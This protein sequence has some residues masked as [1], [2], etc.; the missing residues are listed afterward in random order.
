M[1][2]S[3]NYSRYKNDCFLSS[4]Y[5]M[6]EKECYKGLSLLG[7]MSKEDIYTMEFRGYKFDAVPFLLNSTSYL[8]NEY[9]CAL[10]SSVAKETMITEPFESVDV[11]KSLG[12]DYS[13]YESLIPS[14]V[15]LGIR[16]LGLYYYTKQPISMAKLLFTFFNESMVAV[17][18][19]GKRPHIDFKYKDICNTQAF[20]FYLSLEWLLKI[21]PMLRVMLGVQY[22]KVGVLDLL[23]SFCPEDSIHFKYIKGDITAGELKKLYLDKSLPDG[24]S[25]CFRELTSLS[26]DGNYDGRDLTEPELGLCEDVYNL[27]VD[28]MVYKLNENLS[29]CMLYDGTY[30]RLNKNIEVLSNSVEELKVKVSAEKKLRSEYSDK[31]NNLKKEISEKETEISTLKHKLSSVVSYDELTEKVS[32]LSSEL[33]SEVSE[34]KSLF[35]ERLEL[36]RL[37]SSQSKEIK[38]LKA[39]LDCKENIS[40]G[41]FEDDCEEHDITLDL[42]VE[43]IKDKRVA[44][45]GGLNI[46]SF[47]KKIQG[48]GLKNVTHFESIARSIGTYDCVV[49]L[50]TTVLHSAVYKIEKVVRK[51]NIPLI[52]YNGVNVEKLIVEIYN[53]F[54]E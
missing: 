18:A 28:N 10:Y 3:L 21:N 42:M 49:I 6:L 2:K 11:K 52:Y 51:D 26:T 40:E 31:V 5:S 33:A 45:V 22:K 39:L 50:T 34:N 36:K 53:E 8:S 20:C 27:L 25:I 23:E 54:F 16:G 48:Y 12:I 43:A 24:S 13:I 47:D 7:K 38:K 35:N 44:I 4:T 19:E 30:D 9:R 29:Y 37:V 32:T 17:V 1:S 15:D 41:V 14:G 46:K